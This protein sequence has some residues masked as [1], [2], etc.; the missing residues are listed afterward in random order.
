MG[1]STDTY[2]NSR[3]DVWRASEAGRSTDLQ[4]QDVDKGSTE[5]YRR[6]NHSPR[7]QHARDMLFLNNVT[8]IPPPQNYDAWLLQATA[9]FE[10]E[11]QSKHTFWCWL[12]TANAKQ[13]LAELWECELLR[14]QWVTDGIWGNRLIGLSAT[15]NEENKRL[16]WKKRGHMKVKTVSGT[17][18]VIENS[19]EA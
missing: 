12:I 6:I 7:L 15:L 5:T 17:R 18:P 1:G 16:L 8:L 4:T 13:P 9:A 11:I 3:V 14:W 19:Y 10:G 2:R